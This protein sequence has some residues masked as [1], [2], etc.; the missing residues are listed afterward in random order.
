MPACG[1]PCAYSLQR[2]AL[3]TKV[4]VLLQELLLSDGNT[5]PYD[6]LCVCAGAQ[7]KRVTDSSRE[8]ALR[9][10]QSVQ[11]LCGR[12]PS[13]RTVMVVGNGGIALELV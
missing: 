7:P 5:L 1:F 4:T 6:K 3:C 11:Q 12:L 2:H 9:D 8:L 13:A 10:T